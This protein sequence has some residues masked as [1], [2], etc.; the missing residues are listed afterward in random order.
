MENASRRLRRLILWLRAALYAVLTALSIT[1]VI[2]TVILIP[3]VRR[4]NQTSKALLDCKG[5]PNCLTSMTMAIGGSVRKASGEV[6]KAAPEI[7]SSVKQ[8]TS[9]SADASRKSSELIGDVRA[10]LMGGKDSSG[11][12]LSGVLP[13]IEGLIRDFRTVVQDIRT[14]LNRLTDS[15]D[16]TLRPLQSA[17]K[18]LDETIVTLNT[19]IKEN[20]PELKKA[21]SN[22]ARAIDDFDKLLASDEIKELL[23]HSAG[24]ARNIDDGTESIAVALRPWREKASQLKMILGKIAGF[25]KITWG[26]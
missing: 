8:M 12:Q 1:L 25:F 16:E 7:A 22:A 6:A 17:L 26:F 24:T 13:E 11:R 10:G 18:H 2:I 15:T 9:A 3:T 23:A 14:D 21:L 5:N 20:G 4:I 19:Q